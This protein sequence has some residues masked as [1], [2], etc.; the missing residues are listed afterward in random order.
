[1]KVT[2][3]LLYKGERGTKSGQMNSEEAIFDRLVFFFCYFPGVS[4]RNTGGACVCPCV[5]IIISSRRQSNNKLNQ[6]RKKRTVLTN[7]KKKEEKKTHPLVNASNLKGK[8]E[9]A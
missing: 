8:E 7:N 5:M 1:L 9:A 2:N 3:W 4:E 6:T